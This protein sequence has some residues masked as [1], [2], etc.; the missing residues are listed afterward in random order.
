[1]PTWIE[2]KRWADQFTPHIKAILGQVF[3]EEATV[4]ADR[5]EN[6]DL[7]L[8]M[9]GKRVAVRIRDLAERA[10]Y[11]RR[12]EWTV[13]LRR[14]SETPTELAKLMDGFG[15]YFLYGWGDPAVHRVVAWTVFDLAKVRSWLFAYVMAHHA[16]PG[17]QQDTKDG[18]ARFLALCID[19]MP[20]RCIVHRQTALPGDPDAS[21]HAGRSMYDV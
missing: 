7:V 4:E 9:A 10:A 21:L 16:L 6:T 11:N 13:R 3:I 12:N 15:D 20:P 19:A 18:S 8:V 1:M 17:K 5:T 14:P 2:S